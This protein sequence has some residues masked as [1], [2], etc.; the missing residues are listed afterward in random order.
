MELE[1]NII[2]SAVRTFDSEVQ[3]LTGCLKNE[4][5]EIDAHIHPFQ[6]F[7]VTL[8]DRVD[9]H[10]HLDPINKCSHVQTF[11]TRLKNRGT[12]VET[13]T[14]GPG[15]VFTL[16]DIND[17]VAGLAKGVM[18]YAEQELRSRVETA[19]KK[20][21][22]YKELLYN[23]DQKIEWL[24][25]RLESQASI[26]DKMVNSR[27]YE[28]GNQIVY[29]L[30]QANR[31][32]KLIK[33]NIFQLEKN[34]RHEIESQFRNKLQ[35]TEIMLQKELSKFGEFKQDMQNTVK[36]GI[37]KDQEEIKRV[38]KRTADNFK[39][40]DQSSPA[41]HLVDR[42]ACGEPDALDANSKILTTLKSMMAEKHE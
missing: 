15:Y 6:Q 5:K 13:L 12:E 42:R 40:L 9:P 41:K 2:V 32:L 20:E 25:S 27:M 16:K 11:I 29:E 28:K 34:V 24:Q 18:K 30:D 31:S 26:I 7:A 38:I 17:C 36:A 37:S 14:S 10:S 3:A 1:R 21:Q 39:N 8:Y 22:W 19:S 35:H 23:K 4:S 33:D